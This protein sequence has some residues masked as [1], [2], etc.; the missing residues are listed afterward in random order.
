VSFQRAGYHEWGG[1]MQDDLTDAVQWAIAQGIADPKRVAIV[2]ASYGGYAALAG[3][4]YTP[5]LY[6]CAVNYVGVTDLNL[7]VDSGRVD[8]M[9][10]SES[11]FRQ[12]VGTDGD[13]LRARSPVNFIERLNVPLL[14]AYGENDPR[15]DIRQWKRLKA[16]LDAQKKPYEIII[17]ENEGHGFRNESKRIAFY[18]RVDGFLQ[19]WLAPAP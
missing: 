3:V 2:G 15:V 19:K 9:N 14:N 12:R 7:L 13:V 10:E 8:G 17:E 11:F 1:K 16:K 4:V 6:R 18:R 5:E